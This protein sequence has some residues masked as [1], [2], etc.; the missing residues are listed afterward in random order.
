[1]WNTALLYPLSP[2]YVTISQLSSSHPRGSNAIKKLEAIDEEDKRSRSRSGK[3]RE[4]LTRP[5]K[6][7]RMGRSSRSKMFSRPKM[8][9]N[10]SSQQLKFRS[11]R[12]TLLELLGRA[13]VS[14]KCLI[15][16]PSRFRKTSLTP[17]QRR[18]QHLKRTL[19]DS[20]TFAIEKDAQ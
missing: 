9:D 11:S 17:R 14:E 15:T 12:E 16:P 19:T 2:Q 13:S 7:R 8:V 3:C 5:L 10:L 1:M 18:L 4:C 20:S 6:T